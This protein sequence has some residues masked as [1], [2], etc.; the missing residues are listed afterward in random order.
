MAPTNTALDMFAAATIDNNESPA[1]QVRPRAEVNRRLVES[2]VSSIQDRISS[3]ELS[4]GTWLR[5]ERLA[6]ELGVSRMPVREALRQLQAGGAVEFI[7]RRG[8][9]VRM[10]SPRDVIELYELRGV[11]EGHAAASAALNVTGEQIQRMRAAV[12]SFDRLVAELAEKPRHARTSSRPQWQA[13]NSSFHAAIIEASGN[14]HLAEMI[15]GLHR[16]I[17]KNLTW[18]ALGNDTRRLT[19]NAAEH[20]Q[21]LDAIDAGDGEQ[22][23]ALCVAHAQR[24]SELLVRTLHEARIDGD[25]LDATNN[26]TSLRR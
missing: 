8:A 18:L 21:I 6:Q 3:G 7:P 1:G 14:N 16:K 25:V 26:G 17:P 13:A 22:A 11:L 5:Q 19:R 10:P 9:R 4:V 12:A 15:D 23:R 2:L 20:T 24:A